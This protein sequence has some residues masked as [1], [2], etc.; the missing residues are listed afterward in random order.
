MS[1]MTEAEAA[2]TACPLLALVQSDRW[3][4]ALDPNGSGC[5]A[6]RY[7]MAWR[8]AQPPEHKID[9]PPAFGYRE[10]GYCG[11]AGRPE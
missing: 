9:E 4:H 3:A 11:L 10:R 8:W 6:G 2:K 5:C 1:A 7:C